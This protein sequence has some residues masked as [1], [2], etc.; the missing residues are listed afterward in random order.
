MMHVLYVTYHQLVSQEKIQKAAEVL[1]HAYN[2]GEWIDD[3][4]SKGRL[5]VDASYTAERGQGGRDIH[6]HPVSD[7]EKEGHKKN[8]QEE[9]EIYH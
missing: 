1:K 9:A 2:T 7:G 5:A 8:V 6:S 4:W 3:D